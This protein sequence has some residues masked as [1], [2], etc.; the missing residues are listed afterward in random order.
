M[1]TIR[2]SEINKDV[3]L[4][5][6]VPGR[7][8]IRLRLRRP[9]VL[10]VIVLAAAMVFSIGFPRRYQDDRTISSRSPATAGNGVSAYSPPR[11]FRP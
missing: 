6:R 8:P 7:R 10:A 2:D 11:S 3:A 4:P 1:Q 5:R 9:L